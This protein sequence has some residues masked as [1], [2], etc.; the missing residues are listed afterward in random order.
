VWQVAC[1]P[2]MMK[3]IKE[4]AKLPEKEESQRNLTVAVRVRPINDAEVEYGCT[5]ILHVINVENMVVLMDPSDDPDDILRANR[6]RE[7][8]YVFDLS[9]GPASSQ[10]E[11][12]EQTTKDL[13]E[14]VI[15][16]YNATVFAYGPTGLLSI[17]TYPF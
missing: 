17:L 4:I 16:G 8:Q 13:I 3:E 6:S 15:D 7:K 9:F 2:L 14:S 10:K 11:V 1:T 5:D 12:Y